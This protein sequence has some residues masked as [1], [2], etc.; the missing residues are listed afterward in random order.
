MCNL[1][2][3]VPEE[4]LGCH[5]QCTEIAPKCNIAWK[6]RIRTVEIYKGDMLFLTL[7]YVTKI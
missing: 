4:D 3:T 6:F 5:K 7:G 1:A 2:K